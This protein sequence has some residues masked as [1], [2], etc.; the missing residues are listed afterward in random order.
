MKF[1]PILIASFFFFLSMAR[2]QDLS[3]ERKATIESFIAAL[4]RDNKSQQFIIHNYVYI[5]QDDTISLQ[6]KERFIMNTMDA[7]KKKHSN[8]TSTTGYKIVS[9]D[10]FDGE[11]KL[12]SSP[13]QDIAILTMQ[14]KPVIYFYFVKD[15]IY[16]FTLMEKGKYGYFIVL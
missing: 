12:F 13:T 2:S 15:R 1:F 11:K 8:L 4:F 6:E 14:D 9:Y 16:S 5:P 3:V 7:L 10:E